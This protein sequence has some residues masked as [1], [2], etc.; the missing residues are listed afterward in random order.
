MSDRND[1]DTKRPSD[2]EGQMSDDKQHSMGNR[3][4]AGRD[5]QPA[6]VSGS[7]DDRPPAKDKGDLEGP[8]SGEEK[9]SGTSMDQ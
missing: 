8:L 1:T 2:Q 9:R 6:P 5:A 7:K 4:P 3:T